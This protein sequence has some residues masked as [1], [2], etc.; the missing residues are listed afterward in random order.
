MFLFQK[1]KI[2]NSKKQTLELNALPRQHLFCSLT[3]EVLKNIKKA[4]DISV[5]I[6]IEIL[7]LW[8]TKNN[9]FFDPLK[10]FFKYKIF[11]LQ[12]IDTS[13]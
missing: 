1:I 8:R 10:N 2:D 7:E 13:F 9:P 12:K 3:L 4:N 6:G 5:I 11:F